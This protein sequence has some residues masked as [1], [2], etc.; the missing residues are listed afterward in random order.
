MYS[1]RYTQTRKTSA[2]DAGRTGG[3]S[4]YWRRRQDALVALEL[5]RLSSMVKK[6]SSGEAKIPD[7][8]PRPAPAEDEGYFGTV[9]RVPLTRRTEIYPSPSTRSVPIRRHPLRA[10]TRSRHPRVRRP[11]PPPRLRGRYN[12]VLLHGESRFSDRRSP[13]S[14]TTRRRGETA[15]LLLGERQLSNQMRLSSRE[16]AMALALSPLQKYPKLVSSSLAP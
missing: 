8:D 12:S 7:L 16:L 3:T 11:P 4:L 6:K 10:P 15:D 9:P 5:K 14:S 13:T 1:A 2:K